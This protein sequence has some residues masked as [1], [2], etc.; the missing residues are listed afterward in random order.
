MSVWISRPAFINSRA[1]SDLRPALLVHSTVVDAPTT[2]V[3]IWVWLPT[4]TVLAREAVRQIVA[5]DRGVGLVGGSQRVRLP[6]DVGVVG[7]R[8]PDRIDER[9]IVGEQFRDLVG[10]IFANA[11]AG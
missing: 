3:K 6:F 11:D 5:L 2:L 10:E 8:A 9:G 1:S 4:R 7:R